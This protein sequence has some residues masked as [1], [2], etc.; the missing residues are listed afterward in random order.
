VLPAAGGGSR[1][2]AGGEGGGTRRGEGQQ[3]RRIRLCGKEKKGTRG[4]KVR[5]V[6]LAHQHRRF[7]GVCCARVAANQGGVQGTPLICS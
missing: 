4:R 1:C 5:E 7:G 2:W 6:G 3:R